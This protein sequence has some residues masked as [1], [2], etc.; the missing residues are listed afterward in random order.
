MPSL[1]RGL[2]FFFFFMTYKKHLNKILQDITYLHAE[3]GLT[4]IKLNLFDSG[5][6]DSPYP[7]SLFATLSN[8][9]DVDIDFRNFKSLLL[10]MIV[11]IS[12]LA[13]KNK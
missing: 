6:V 13:I 12:L 5:K 4:D 9:L 1:R 2:Y 10:D 11:D 3:L 8:T 7:H